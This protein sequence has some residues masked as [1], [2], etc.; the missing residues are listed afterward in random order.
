LEM[1]SQARHLSFTTT[2]SALEAAILESDEIKRLSPPYNRALVTKDRKTVFF[3]E[4]LQKVRAR[5]DQSHK[6]GPIPSQGFLAPL[7][8]LADV[9]EGKTKRLSSK[10]IETIL[11]IPQDYIPTVACFKEGIRAFKQDFLREKKNLDM[12]TLKSLGSLFWAEKLEAEKAAA[13]ESQ[14]QKETNTRKEIEEEKDLELISESA[15][16]K[17][18]RNEWTP[19]RVAK[20]IKSV[21]RFGAFQIRRAGWFCRLSESTLSWTYPESS[22]GEKNVVLIDAGRLS[23]PEPIPIAAKIPPPRRHE[24]SLKERQTGFDIAAYDRMRVV[25]TEIRRLLEE[26]RVVELCL[27][28]DVLLTN[29]TLKKMLTWL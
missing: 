10:Q 15:H 11:N 17:L 13:E 19:E 7:A 3:S 25:T 6:V 2:G 24:S 26:G 23:F 18:S 5:P 9:L 4:D 27:H 28:P 12:R 14:K 1:L 8:K 22:G 16:E 20:A 29:T 21:I